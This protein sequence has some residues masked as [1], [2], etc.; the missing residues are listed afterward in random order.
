MEDGPM[1][2]SKK[3]LEILEKALAEE[4]TAIAQYMAHHYLIDDAGYSKLAEM[5]KEEAVDEMKHAEH[6]AERIMFLGEVPPYKLHAPPQTKKA[7]I[8]D[9]LKA[10]LSLEEGAIDLYNQGIQICHAEGDAGSRLLLEKILLDEEKHKQDLQ[11]KLDLIKLH[12]DAY[13]VSLL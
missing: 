9:L 3:V 12:G 11:E 10:D 4:H 1:K 2:K 7:P 5:V 8:A 6:L 13:W